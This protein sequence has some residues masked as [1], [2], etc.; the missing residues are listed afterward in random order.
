MDRK[1]YWND[2]YVAYWRDRVAESTERGTESSVVAGDA[3]TEGDEI[4]ERIFAAT[5]FSAG[6][7]LDV[8]CAWGRMFALFKG[9]GLRV[10]GVDISDAMI[11]MARDQWQG[12]AAVDDLREAEAE[13]L[14]FADESFDNVTCL[15]VFDATY[16]AEALT[17]FSRVLRPGG[18]LYVTGK[19]CSYRED[20]DLALDAELGARKKG[21]PNYFTDVDQLLAQL[22]HRG[23]KLL[24]AYY[25]EKRGDFAKFKFVKHKPPKFYEYFLIVERGLRHQPFETL[26]DAY[27]ETFK[28]SDETERVGLG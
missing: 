11:R 13:E 15:A 10:T 21:H 22:K 23:H 17:E 8:G 26:S 3:K 16:Q 24:D 27:S 4:Y 19:N 9:C 1:Q 7:L 5:P 2:T 18:R 12:D 14:P 20:D 6:S 28:R 25:F